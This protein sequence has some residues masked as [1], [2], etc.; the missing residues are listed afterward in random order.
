M[1]AYG[2]FPKTGICPVMFEL[3]PARVLSSVQNYSR[4]FGI[5]FNCTSF[6]QL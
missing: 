5:D 4:V 1:R 3:L 6:D 2:V